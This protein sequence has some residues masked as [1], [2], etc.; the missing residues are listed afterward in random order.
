VAEWLFYSKR[1]I[2]TRNEGKKKGLSVQQK[3]IRIEVARSPGRNPALSDK[4]RETII[5]EPLMMRLTAQRYL[6]EI[7]RWIPDNHCRE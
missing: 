7:T 6:S 2:F 4:H 3:F 1:K 5:S